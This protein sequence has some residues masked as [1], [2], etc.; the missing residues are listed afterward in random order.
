MWCNVDKTVIIWFVFKRYSFYHC[1][2]TYYYCFILIS[3]PV[4]HRLLV[5]SR[6]SF[7]ST[8]SSDIK[9]LCFTTLSTSFSHFT[10]GRPR[11]RL[12]SGDQVIIRLGHLLSSIRTT[13]PYNFNVL[14]SSL[15][16]IVCVT[17]FL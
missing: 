6:H 12:P 3:F 14:F 2:K 4:V 15:S 16:K 8:A 1:T 10:S 5:V 13:C 9:L 7:R 11:H 17:F